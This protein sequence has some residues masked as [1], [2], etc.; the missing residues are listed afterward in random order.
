MKIKIK[1]L[2]PVYTGLLF[3]LPLLQGFSQSKSDSTVNW[4]TI[5]E[6]KQ[7]MKTSPRPTMVFFYKPDQDTSRIMLDNTLNRKEICNYVNSRFYAVKI[8]VTTTDTIHWFDQKTYTCKAN[9][10]VN[11]LIPMLL[12]EKP[13]SP[14]L[15]FLNPGSSSFTFKGF[16]NRYEI[17]CILVYFYEEINKTTPFESWVQAYMVAYPSF[18]LPK[19]LENPIKWHTLEEALALQKKSPK[20]LFINWY[21]RLNVGS[22]VMLFNA[23]EDPKVAKYLNENFYCVRLDAQ[24]KD[25]LFWDKAYFNEPVKSR[26]NQ[27][28]LKQLGENLKFPALLFFDK[29]LNLIVD[30][31]YYLGTQKMQALVN[32]AGSGAYRNV[33]FEDY[34][35]SF[36]VQR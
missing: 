16:K 5:A 36:K 21:A 34:C 7:L 14:A 9:G 4:R 24:T 31:Q 27:L 8:D 25:T 32:Y 13:A 30:K 1:I 35:K 10:A 26:Y 15:L 12:G 22:T 6:V 17:R 20:G 29:S 28:A 18:G 3:F 19:S 2:I 11:D 23:F 33:N